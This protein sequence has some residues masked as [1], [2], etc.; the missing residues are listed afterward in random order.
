MRPSVLD[1]RV[2]TTRLAGVL[3][4]FIG[5]IVLAWGVLAQWEPVVW[6]TMFL[7]YAGPCFVAGGLY[8]LAAR[9]QDIC[10]LNPE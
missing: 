3:L 8:L 1:W 4:V 7:L 2:G 9:M 5:V 10:T 6:G